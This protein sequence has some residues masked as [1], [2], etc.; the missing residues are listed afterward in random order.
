MEENAKNQH[1][2]HLSL[3]FVENDEELSLLAQNVE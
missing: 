3:I 2:Q 1:C